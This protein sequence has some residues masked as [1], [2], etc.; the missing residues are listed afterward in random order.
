MSFFGFDPTRP[1]PV[2]AGFS[3]ARDPFAGLSSHDDDGDALDFEDTYDGL[4]D[5]LDETDDAFNDDTFGD[6][7]GSA[8]PAPVGKDFDFFG[9]TA[10]VANAIEEE[11]VRFN[12][13][14]PVARAA[15]PISQPAPSAVH[16]HAPQATTSYN[17]AP[18]PAYKPARTGYEKYSQEPVD[19]LQVDAALW[20]VAPKKHAPAPP[21]QTHSPATVPAGRKMMSL[22]EVEAQMRAQAKRPAEPVAPSPVPQ[23]QLQQPQVHY[24]PGYQFQQPAH[25]Q[26]PAH[27]NDQQYH[28]GH[29][30][31]HPVTILQRPQSKHATQAP[32]PT[33]HTPGQH[34]AHQRPQ[35]T[36]P[37][38]PTQILQ[39]PSRL[40]GDAARLG[41]HSHPTPPGGY[42]THPTHRQQ[43]SLSRQQ[44]LV[45]HPSQLSQLSEEEKTAYMDQEAKR[46][47]RNHKIFLM[48]RDN[49]IM[50]PQDKNFVTRIQLQ[51]LVA[52]TGN[53]NEHGT[54]E[55]LAED[56]YYQVH[57]QIQGGHRQHP[58]QPLNNFAQTYL[59]QTGSRHGGLRRH[60]RGPEN[61]MQRMEQQ[62]QR[63]VEAAKNKPKN[64]QLVIE[65]SLGKISF[66]N[67]KTPKPLLNIKRNDT[68]GETARPSSAHKNMHTPSGR[69]KK[70]EL[71]SI[72]LVYSTL[73]KME[74]H[75]RM[76]PPPP[77]GEADTHAIEKV[78]EWNTTAQALNKK[79]W[80]ALR[81]HD[82]PQPG[83]VHP[84]IA[85]LSYTKGK[86]AMERIFRHATLEQRTIILTL[87]VVNLDELDVV[88]GAQVTTGDIQLN[89][90]MR[91]NVELFSVAVMST[92][93]NFMNELDLDLV[94]GVLGLVCT[95]N[96]DVIA[97]SRI[98][99]SMLTMILSRAEIIKH[100][101]GGTSQ[102]WQSWDAAYTQLFNL[103]EPSLPY[104]FPGTVNSGDDV[105]VWQLLAAIGIGA[106][107]DQQQRLV[108]AVKDRVMDTV[109]LAK[110]L[111]HDLSAQRLQNV[112]LFM[113]SI[114]LDVELLQ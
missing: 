83:C 85:L 106:S 102:S 94:A 87:I 63:A 23:Q 21:P 111:P 20:G 3:Q 24:D 39:N 13:Q 36:A 35:P 112:N 4:G 2:G 68:A 86:K 55:S 84:F 17:Y 113:R 53:P 78:V 110:T 92:L 38:Q 88:R 45:T 66:S 57:N 15:Q 27:A 74:D 41:A 71:R 76:M 104:I 64:K 6:T 103:L 81:V 9:Q 19:E 97:K 16:T 82:H 42:P 48:S 61:H 79:L 29:G 107:P 80:T 62:V 90:A 10:K 101:G 98:G 73:M 1:N 18:Q 7:G 91:E 47:K 52:A 95:R 65:G 99:A 56:F 30:H 28:P 89:A 14:A 108:L 67:A 49:G 105:Y 50:T 25:P 114:G 69:D 44:Q 70:S 100:S 58:S 12:R 60:H 5:Q 8:A 22:E 75:D 33:A 54:D 72:E 59:F 109:N 51:Q 37:V 40:S 96:I 77:S 34:S 11:H 46:A 31:G 93:F 26:A 43:G 32:P